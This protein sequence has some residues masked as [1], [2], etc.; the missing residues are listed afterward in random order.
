MHN[1]MKRRAIGRKMVAFVAEF[2][3][4]AGGRNAV[5]DISALVARERS[6]GGAKETRWRA[7]FSM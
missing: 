7:K 5:C 4:A 6:S 3:Q 1:R 2:R